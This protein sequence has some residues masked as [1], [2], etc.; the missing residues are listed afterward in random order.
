MGEL[1]SHGERGADAQ[2]A[3]R[4]RIHPVPGSPGLHG[5][6]TD[7]DHV[8]AVADIDRVFGQELVEL[9]GDAVGMNGG[10]LGS[11]HRLQLF[12]GRVLRGAQFVHPRLAPF[13]AAVDPAGYRVGHR[14]QDYPR[15]A[16]EAERD[17]AVLAYRPVVHIDLDHRR[18]GAQ[19]PAVA[20]AEI[21]RRADDDD[22][23]G[24]IE[25]QTAGA[26]EEMRVAGRQRPAART[27]HIGRDVE[28]PHQLHRRIPA[29]A[30][31][32]LGAKQDTWPLRGDQDVRQ[33]LDVIRVP[34]RPGRAPVSAGGGDARTRQRDPGVQHVSGDFEE[35]GTGRS[36]MGFPAGHGDHIR[37]ALSPRH[38]RG[39][40]GHRSHHV[41]M[42]QILERSHLVLAER[43]LPADHQDR[44]FGAERVGDTGHGVGRSRP[45]R[46]HDAARSAGLPG[47]AVGG[48]G[49]HLFV[50][51][52]EDPDAFVQAS[53]VDVDDVPAAQREDHVH[54]FVL[55][56]LGDQASAGDGLPGGI[57][58]RRAHGFHDGASSRSGCIR[59][60][61]GTP[62]RFP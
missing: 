37:D 18:S 8:P 9:V 24:P 36:G 31:P 15:V 27:V 38:G 46:R 3:E 11:E 49:R 58:I 21:E 19:P 51:D 60:R 10:G 23:V 5:L 40:L 30:G 53:V 25:G 39:E 44:A 48:V 41:H 34:E 35:G 57:G 62:T 47:V 55:E 7:R 14:L 32:Y 2:R 29:A 16:G 4:A 56:R 45:R 17:V 50:P 43:A 13:P 28:P 54:A 26:V 1:G 22:H 12:E 33:P 59:I 42:R 20:H 6:G 52:V 61:H